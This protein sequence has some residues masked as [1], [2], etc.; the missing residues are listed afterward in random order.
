MKS[1][2]MTFDRFLLE[3]METSGPN[4]DVW[5]SKNRDGLMEVKGLAA[6]LGLVRV[7]VHCPLGVVFQ[8]YIHICV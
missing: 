4:P 5:K 7:I 3:P 1:V 8:E 2:E 6:V